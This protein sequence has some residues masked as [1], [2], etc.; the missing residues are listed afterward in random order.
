MTGRGGYGSSGRE[1]SRI[2]INCERT[3][4]S[5]VLSVDKGFGGEGWALEKRLKGGGPAMEDS[6]TKQLGFEAT[7][8]IGGY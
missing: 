6:E 8:V 4:A 1:Q 3:G 5:E 2:K 7:G